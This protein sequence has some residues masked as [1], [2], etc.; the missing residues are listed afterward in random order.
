MVQLSME[1]RVILSQLHKS[2]YSDAEIGQRL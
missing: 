2:N 1:E